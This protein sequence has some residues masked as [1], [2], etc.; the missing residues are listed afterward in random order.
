[1]ASASGGGGPA[2]TPK[3][4][5]LPTPRN[6]LAAATPHTVRVGAPP[7]YIVIPNRISTW[8]NVSTGNIVGHGDCVTAEEAFAKACYQPEIFISDQEVINWATQHGVLEGAYIYQVL[9]WMRNDGFRQDGKIYDDGGRYSVDWTQ[10]EILKSA[11]AQGPVKIGVAADQ[12]V[13]LC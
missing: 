2:Q 10:S 8:G 3:R 1:M 7:E 6:M 9:D 12:L 11:I 4:G 5:A 13:L